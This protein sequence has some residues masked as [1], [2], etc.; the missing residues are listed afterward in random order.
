MAIDLDQV[1]ARKPITAL[2]PSLMKHCIAWSV[3]AGY[4]ILLDQASGEANTPSPRINRG[5]STKLKMSEP[6][7]HVETRQDWAALVSHTIVGHPRKSEHMAEGILCRVLQVMLSR[8][9]STEVT[10]LTPGGRFVIDASLLSVESTG[11]SEWARYVH[12]MRSLWHGMQM[13]TSSLNSMRMGPTSS[14]FTLSR[15]NSKVSRASGVSGRPSEAERPPL[16]KALPSVMTGLTR[17][18]QGRSNSCDGT[19]CQ[20]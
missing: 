2:Q 14:R 16:S 1:I 6:D 4:K 20:P 9:A 5:G 15:S 12:A 7:L 10:Q 17:A 11:E 13:R 3:S 8:P 18:R 19:C